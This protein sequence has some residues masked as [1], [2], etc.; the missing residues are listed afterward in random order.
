MCSLLIVLYLFRFIVD[1]EQ[2]TPLRLAPGST[3]APGEQAGGEVI[4]LVLELSPAVRTLMA[5]PLCED[6]LNRVLA[7]KVIA[8]VSQK[9]SFLLFSCFHLLL[10]DLLP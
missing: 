5:N 7:S 9:S 6:K 4:A 10:F 3:G 1:D 2:V 8:E